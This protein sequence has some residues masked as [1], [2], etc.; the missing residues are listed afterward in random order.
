MCEFGDPVFSSK[1]A[2]P[3]LILLT[4][5]AIWAFKEA[6]STTPSDDTRFEL[7]RRVIE[8]VEGEAIVTPKK[9][10][11]AIMNRVEK[12]MTNDLRV[13]GLEVGNYKR[14][15]KLKSPRAFAITFRRIWQQTTRRSVE[16]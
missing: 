14:V 2:N 16:L 11:A 13:A 5:C 8:L 12:C 3:F 10:I 15:R 7:L 1:A 6:G 9:G 4:V